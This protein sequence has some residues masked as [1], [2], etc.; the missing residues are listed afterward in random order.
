MCDCAFY[1]E[2]LQILE[3]GVVVECDS[4][5]DFEV[6]L[7]KV[8]SRTKRVPLKELQEIE[9]NYVFQIIEFQ[10]I[11]KISTTG[12]LMTIQ[13]GCTQQQQGSTVFPAGFCNAVNKLETDP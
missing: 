6:D 9:I 4:S 5:A 1:L 8:E 3:V 12:L 10:L 11:S 2:D 13:Q 7:T